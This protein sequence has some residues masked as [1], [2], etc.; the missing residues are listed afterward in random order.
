MSSKDPA[1]G[2]NRYAV[3]AQRHWQQWLP[4]RY[5]ALPASERESYFSCLGEEAASQ[6]ANLAIELAGDTPAGE[7]YL[8]RVGRL[9]MSRL[10]AEEVV[11][12]E[13]ILI[14]PEPEIDEEEEDPENSITVWER[15]KV[16]SDRQLREAWD[17]GRIADERYAREQRER[18]QRE[19]R[20]RP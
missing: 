6:I 2:M 14:E 3:M 15:S 5:A 10:Q 13:L 7:D 9:N 8:T 4:Q 20:Q 16:E 18:R 19:Q 1:P 17:P 11:L 12:P